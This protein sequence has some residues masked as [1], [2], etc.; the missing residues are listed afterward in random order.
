MKIC[1]HPASKRRRSAKPG[2]K[3]REIHRTMRRVTVVPASSVSRRERGLDMRRAG[4]KACARRP[5][6]GGVRQSSARARERRHAVPPHSPRA[7]ERSLRLL[8]PAFSLSL[9]L[10][11]RLRARKLLPACTDRYISFGTMWPLG[12]NARLQFRIDDWNDFF[13]KLFQFSEK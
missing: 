1:T 2:G 7:R 3:P 6:E 10:P 4:N 11:I 13:F 5:W 8:G 9:S 12:L